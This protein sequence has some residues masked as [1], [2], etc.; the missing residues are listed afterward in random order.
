M[1]QSLNL[2]I[3]ADSYLPSLVKKPYSKFQT[4]IWDFV[5]FFGFFGHLIHTLKYIE[6]EQGKN[7]RIGRLVK[8]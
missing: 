7:K 3:E 8:Y 2:K 4:E 5:Q 6:L 1:R